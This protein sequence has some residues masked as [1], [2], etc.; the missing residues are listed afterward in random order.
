[1]T[2]HAQVAGGP[3]CRATDV[4][5]EDRVIGG[6]PVDGRGDEL[7]VQRGTCAPLG[8]EV[9]QASPRP[10]V[11]RGHP[12]QVP[13][14]GLLRQEGEQGVDR[15]LDGAGERDVDGHPPTD[16]VG[17]HVGLATGTPSG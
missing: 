3:D 9:I 4:G 15:V 8:G 11:V 13:G 6:Q 12:I 1:M 5:D 17:S 2:V 16:L 14:V 10:P 7:G